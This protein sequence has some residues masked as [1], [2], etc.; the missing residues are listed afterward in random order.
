MSWL[1]KER[2]AAAARASSRRLQKKGD[3]ESVLY[4]K[5]AAAAPDSV[6][7]DLFT[8]VARRTEVLNSKKNYR[9]HGELRILSKA[10]ESAADTR[11]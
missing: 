5:M 6:Y 11:L 10:F 1:K 7:E 4:E 2:E 9:Q 8:Y 3:V